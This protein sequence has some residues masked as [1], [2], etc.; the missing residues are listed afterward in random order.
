MANFLTAQVRAKRISPRSI[1]N[2]LFNII[3]RAEKELAAYNAATIYEDSQDVNGKPIGYYSEATELIT[4]GRK[5]A[6]DP[7][8]LFETGEFLEGLYAKVQGNTIYFDS[9]D[10]KKKAVLK[11]TL[12]DDIFGLQDDD[13]RKAID[14]RILPFFLDAIR[15]QI[16]Q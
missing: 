5:K 13:L 11:N 4:G 8:T 14:T 6:G 2:E 3:R 12:T 7:F 15:K 10:P 9:S 16:F 1:S